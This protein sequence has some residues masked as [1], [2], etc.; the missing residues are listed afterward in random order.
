MQSNCPEGHVSWNGGPAGGTLYQVCTIV[1][2][3]LF[4][5]TS[6]LQPFIFNPV[7]SLIKL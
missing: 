3:D 4:L 7:I 1:L 5:E 6:I 2:I